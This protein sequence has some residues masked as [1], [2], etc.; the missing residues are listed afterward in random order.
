MK[1]WMLVLLT[2]LMLKYIN[3]LCNRI[4]FVILISNEAYCA[5]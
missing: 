4:L 1:L 3:I 5:T 2:I